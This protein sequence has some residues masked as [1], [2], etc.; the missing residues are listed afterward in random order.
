MQMVCEPSASNPFTGTALRAFGNNLGLKVA[1]A[2]RAVV[3]SRIL[4]RLSALSSA[5]A[6][7]PRGD[8]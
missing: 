2:T 4:R 8:L 7:E 5:L 1:E 6:D 3:P